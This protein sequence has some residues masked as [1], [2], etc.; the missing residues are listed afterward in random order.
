MER[1]QVTCAESTAY[2]GGTRFDR[3]PR[4]GLDYREVTRWLAALTRLL[5]SHLGTQAG[6]VLPS[7]AAW[8]EPWGLESRCS[9]TVA[10]KDGRSRDK[11]PETAWAVR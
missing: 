11:A 10:I 8:E 6:E 7:R 4:I 9:K 5:W 1:N 2:R 3:C